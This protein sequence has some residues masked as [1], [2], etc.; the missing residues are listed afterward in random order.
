MRSL[1]KDG[2]HGDMIQQK[3]HSYNA[4][5][6]EEIC[7]KNRVMTLSKSVLGDYLPGSRQ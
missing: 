2:G 7:K 6:G 3:T 4:L 1:E 5:S